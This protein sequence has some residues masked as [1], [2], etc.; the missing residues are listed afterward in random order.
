[1]NL[2]HSEGVF[3][4][5]SV[6]FCGFLCN[7]VKYC[8]M[9]LTEGMMGWIVLTVLSLCR[10]VW[11]TVKVTQPYRVLSTDGTAQIQC[12]VHPRPSYHQIEPSHDQNTSY[13][14]PDPEELS[15]TLL[16]GL[17]GSQELCSSS[18]NFLQKPNETDVKQ[19]G[20]VQCSAQATDG[21][22]T[23]SVSGLKATD[24]DLYRCEIQIFYPPPYLRFTGNGTLIHV[25]DHSGC[26]V[27]EA[28]KQISHQSEEDEEET[29]LP[30]V[31]SSAADGVPVLALLIVIMCV[32]VVMIYFQTL[33]CERSRREVI[34]TV[35]GVIHKMDAASFPRDNMA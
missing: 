19:E 15:V 34:R 10:P 20:E 27:Q 29:D 18:I 4:R 32:L 17:H 31:K 1:M 33:Q 12:V 24:T 30:V 35:S 9:F 28:Q 3:H 21:A 6:I 8:R 25:L 7:S 13:P 22:V 5:R 11:S 16:K 23:V 14:F 26:P 2:A